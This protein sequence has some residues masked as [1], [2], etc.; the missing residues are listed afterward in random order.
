MIF[1]FS[2]GSGG[3][4]GAAFNWLALIPLLLQ[5]GPYIVAEIGNALLEPIYNVLRMTSTQA[6]G[7]ASG[8][9]VRATSEVLSAAIVSLTIIGICAACVLHAL[10]WVSSHMDMVWDMCWHSF[11]VC[12][13]C[14]CASKNRNPS[15]PSY[16]QVR[17]NGGMAYLKRLVQQSLSQGQAQPARQH[18]AGAQGPRRPPRVHLD[19][20][21]SALH[22][23]PM[24]TFKTQE[25]L[26]ACSVHELKVRSLHACAGAIFGT[27]V[28]PLNSLSC[29]RTHART[30]G[31]GVRRHHAG[32]HAAAV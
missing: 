29:W 22:K 28:M 19:A 5:F 12:F 4:R 18:G 17:R 14:V 10:V 7:H 20:V 30:K 26:E 13:I 21:A 16:P 9:H 6:G 32:L 2:F 31:L 11:T 15:A 27:L 8:R 24:D 23:L 3:L 1:F 25:E